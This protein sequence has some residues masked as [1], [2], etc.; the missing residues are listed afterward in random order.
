MTMVDTAGSLVRGLRQKLS[1]TQEELAHA[2]DMTLA[3]VN[4]WENAHAEPSKLAWKVIRDFA[5][6]RGLTRDL[7]EPPPSRLQPTSGRFEPKTST[8]PQSS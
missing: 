2:L 6:A 1:L 8:I 4:R 3:S 7:I 5:Q